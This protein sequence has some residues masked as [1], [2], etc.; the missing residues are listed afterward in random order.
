M[1]S[2]GGGRSAQSEYRLRE[3][4]G[5]LALLDVAIFTGR[6]HQIRVHLLEVG[7]AI[8]NDD[9]YGGG[10]NG[11]LRKFLRDGKD[12]GATRQWR[13][14][15]P[16]AEPRR[17]LTHLLEVYP[18]IFLH[19]RQLAFQHPVTGQGMS[20]E[21]ELPDAWQQVRDTIPGR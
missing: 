6:T 7:C 12:S 15:W 20:F 2:G 16:D 18:G 13:Q 21:S 19:A 4:W 1:W 14:T 11:A 3:M 17:Q 9:K 8:L 5:P 10:R